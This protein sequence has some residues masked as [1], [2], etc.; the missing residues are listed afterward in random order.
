M[1]GPLIAGAGL[2]AGLVAFSTMGVRSGSGAFPIFAG[3]AGATADGRPGTGEP[4]GRRDSSRASSKVP[5]IPQKRKLS[6]LSSPH[7]GQIT[8]VLQ[9]S[10][11]TV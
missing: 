11:S 1:E 9:M 6:E 3:T 8:M 7:F 5:H 10:L 4:A 2:F